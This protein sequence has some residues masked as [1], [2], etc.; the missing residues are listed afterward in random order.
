MIDNNDFSIPSE[1]VPSSTGTRKLIGAALVIIALI[2]SF[3]LGYVSGNKGFVFDPK[4]FKVINQNEAP[5]T[6]D[7]NLLWDALSLVNKNYIDKGSINQQNVLYGAIKGA[8]SAA[9]DQYT[10]YFTPKEL[11]DFN[12]QLGGSFEGIGAEVGKVDG[13]IVLTPLDDSPAAKAGVRAKDIIVKIN[14]ESTADMSVDDA[15]AK[16]RGQK[17]TTVTLTLFREGQ[18]GTFDL[19]I[20]R[21]TITLKSVKLTYK[22]VGDKKIAVITLTQF[23][24]DTTGAFGQ[25]VNDLIAAGAKGLVIDERNNPGGYLDAA[26]DLASYWLPKGQ[27]VVTEARS[28]SDNQ[29]Y[30]SLGY[31]RLKGIKTVF[32]LNGGSASAA[33]IL[34]GALHDHGAAELVGEKSFGKGSVQQLFN[35]PD[36]KGAVKITVA[37]WIT[38]NGKNLNKDGLNPDVEVKLTDDDIKNNRDPQM[39]RALQ[40]VTK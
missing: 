31:D 23:G 25:A 8:V 3:R 4:S 18:S 14:G 22:Q 30:N 19:G 5:A 15:V 33:E 7:Y 10:T 12:T 11:A 40:E 35:L 9:G 39:D 2:A 16:I 24:S 26:V 1:P 20:K 6:V 32:L 13:N 21:D 34:A 27:L 38:P 36:N 29:P 17:G 28:T 37:K